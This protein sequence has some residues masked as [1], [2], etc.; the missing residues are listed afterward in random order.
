MGEDDQRGG[1]V[2][3]ALALVGGAYGVHGLLVRGALTVDLGVGRRVRPLGPLSVR[4][5]GPPD[6]VF[7]VI[8]APYLGRT[9]GATQPKSSTLERGRDVALAAHY[10]PLGRLTPTRVDTVRF[11][12]PHRAAFRLVRGRAHVIETYALETVH[13]STTLAYMGELRTV[14]WQLGQWWGDRV[15][16]PWKRT[17][18]DSLGSIRTEAERRGR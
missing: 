12:R 16:G 4:I 8:A 15:A 17:V 9:P 2:S 10:T 5:A 11:A 13:G 18:A 14:L 6:T 1:T 3:C 7:E